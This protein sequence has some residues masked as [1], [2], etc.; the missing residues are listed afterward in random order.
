[1]TR[2][3]QFAKQA[4]FKNI[5]IPFDSWWNDSCPIVPQK[6]TPIKLK[7][8]N[9]TNRIL[10]FEW[11][12]Q[13]LN[14]IYGRSSNHRTSENNAMTKIATRL[15]NGLFSIITTY[16]VTVYFRVACDNHDWWNNDIM[17]DDNLCIRYSYRSRSQVL[18]YYIISICVDTRRCKIP[19]FQNNLH[20]TIRNE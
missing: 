3:R 10:I 2:E 6:A 7:Y 15:N 9:F 18:F 16:R 12:T 17:I 20:N 1:M 11:G 19:Q 8:R 13:K 4:A 14:F 5:D